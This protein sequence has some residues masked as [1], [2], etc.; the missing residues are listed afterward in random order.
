MHRVSLYGV[1]ENFS[2]FH[3]EKQQVV[4]DQVKDKLQLNLSAHLLADLVD[5]KSVVMFGFVTNQMSS[6]VSLTMSSYFHNDI[7]KP[8]RFFA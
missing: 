4:S 2:G 3:K 6:L 7:F 5:Q 1:S 8:P